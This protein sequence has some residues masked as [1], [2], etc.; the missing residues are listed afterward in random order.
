ML[1]WNP[2]D[3]LAISW[4]ARVSGDEAQLVEVSFRAVQ[5]GTEVRLVHAGWEKLKV[6]A[7]EW[8]DKYEGG[9]VEVFERCF[10]DFADKAG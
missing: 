3:G 2:P 4:Q 9:W 8:R 10:K 5:D 1:E 6:D 7:R